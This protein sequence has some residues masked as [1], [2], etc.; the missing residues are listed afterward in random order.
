VS[1][2]LFLVAASGISASPVT[3]DPP[4][5]PETRCEAA[6]AKRLLGKIDTPRVRRKALKLAGAKT[7]RALD[8][9]A[10]VTQ[11]YAFGRL[12]LIVDARHVIIDIH[13]G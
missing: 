4:L 10:I 5:A 8:Q 7:I 12:N 11:E 9:S 3:L 2:L 1:M 13:C 6:P